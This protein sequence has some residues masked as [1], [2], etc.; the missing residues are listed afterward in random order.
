MEQKTH[1]ERWVDA[2]SVKERFPLEYQYMKG[3]AEIAVE[4][5]L[6]SSYLDGTFHFD[7][8]VPKISAKGAN[9]LLH[10]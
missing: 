7:E 9:A 2:K 10:Q 6:I 5:L 4:F 1:H 8:L 3:Y